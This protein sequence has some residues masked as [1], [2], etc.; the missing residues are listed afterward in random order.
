MWHIIIEFCEL[1]L[2]RFCI[3]L[4]TEKLTN[5]DENITSLVA[6]IIVLSIYLAKTE[7]KIKL[8]IQR[9]VVCTRVTITWI[10]LLQHND[11][12]VILF[13]KAEQNIAV[14]PSQLDVQ[15]YGF[16]LIVHLYTGSLHPQSTTLHSYDMKHK[17]M[18]STDCEKI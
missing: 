4:L 6:I 13:R 12:L 5:A 16:A 14:F 17:S 15:K 2:S 8:P 10:C 11:L 9:T 7:T 18:Y 3:I 1:W